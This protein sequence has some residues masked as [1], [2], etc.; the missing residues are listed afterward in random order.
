MFEDNKTLLVE[1][2]ILFIGNVQYGE[3]PSGGGAQV[4][5][6]IFLKYLQEYFESVV[7]CDTWHKNHLVALIVSFF[8]IIFYPDRKIIL[9]LSFRGVY[10]LSI[11]LT[12]LKIK[13]KID[14]WMVGDSSQTIK[15]KKYH[16][17]KYFQE[18]IVQGK[19]IADDLEKLGLKNIK[20]VQNFKN[21]NYFPKKRK[22]NDNLVR[23]V[24]M[25]RLIEE[26]GVG[27][28]L[29]AAHELG[30]IGY[31]IDFYGSLHA[32]YSREYFENSGLENVYYKG[33]LNLQQRENYD[34]LASYDVMLFP[35]YF[36]GEGFPGVL[37]D[38][39]IAGLPVIA[40]NFHA[41]PEVIINGKNGIIIL[42]K[43]LDELHEAMSGFVNG[44]YNLE[45]MRIDAQRSAKL[46]D[47]HNVLNDNLF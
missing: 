3:T 15:K 39:F 24:Y 19:Y 5:N 42:P 35:T 13:R 17:L 16:Y 47:V 20:V 1:K 23:F 14:W 45:Q 7:F 11:I 10:I 28:I 31:E 46:Y 37:I 33:F 44:T 26:K 18:I 36:E 32:P 9:S 29:D 25:S 6:Q 21:I 40:S 22:R 4:K 34:V 27:L 8:M 38:A 41:N 12:K 2:K 30:T 43:N